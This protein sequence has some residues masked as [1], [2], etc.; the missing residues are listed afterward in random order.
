MDEGLFARHAVQLRKRKD[1][2]VEIIGLVKK[3]TGI[4][5]QEDEFSISKKH[6]T[7]YLSSVKKSMLASKNI[8]A[9]LESRGYT[10][11]S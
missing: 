6:V 5:L 1:V 7:L 8:K 3:E 11:R 2:K 4:V 10:L 9:L